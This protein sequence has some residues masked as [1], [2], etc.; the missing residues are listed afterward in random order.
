MSTK[1]KNQQNQKL[2]KSLPLT[3]SPSVAVKVETGREPL[4]RDHKGSL[5]ITKIR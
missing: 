5:P 4:S 2:V 3:L 1:Q